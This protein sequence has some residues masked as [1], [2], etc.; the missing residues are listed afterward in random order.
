MKTIRK[1]STFWAS[2][3]VSNRAEIGSSAHNV[4]ASDQVMNKTAAYA[5]HG[6]SRKR[7]GAAPRRLASEASQARAS[8][9]PAA[10]SSVS[11]VVGEPGRRSKNVSTTKKAS[12]AARLRN[13]TQTKARPT[14]AATASVGDRVASPPMAA[15][16]RTAPR[17]SPRRRAAS[18]AGGRTAVAPRG[19]RDRRAGNA[20]THAGGRGG[21][22]LAFVWVAFRNLAAGLAF[23]VVL[24][25]FERHGARRR[26][27]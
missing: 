23:F 17:T 2:L 1:K 8:M 20:V 15:P 19:R 22:G 3:P 16:P 14:T 4:E 24:T 26:P 6:W 11:P 18:P 25:F 21:S 10:L 27:G 9:N 13:A 7:S 12:P 5:S